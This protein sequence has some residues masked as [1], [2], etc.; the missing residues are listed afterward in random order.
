MDLR[1]STE[2]AL[3][4]GLLMS[5]KRIVEVVSVVS[6]S[7]FSDDMARESFLRIVG[8]WKDGRHVDAVTVM[9]G[10]PALVVFLS[11]AMSNASP[12]GVVDYARTI[13][14]L[15]R[16]DRINARLEK[17]S[18]EADNR[19]KLSGIMSLYQDEMHISAK[20]PSIGSVV[21][22]IEKRQSEDKK[23]G[24]F[25]FSTGFD[26]L[27]EIYVK[28]MPGHIWTMGAFTSVGKTAMMIQ[29][30]CNL[31]ISEKTPKMVIISTEMTEGQL[32]SRMLSNF[33]G[34]HSQRI[35]TAN[36]RQGEEEVVQEYKNMLKSK[37]IFI[38]DDIYELSDIETVF[39]KAK[40]KTGV[41]VG[42]IDYVQNCQVPDAKSQYQEQ[43]T[44]AK[45]IQKLAKDVDATII[46][47]SQVSN[48][49]GRGNTSQLE[50]KGAGEWAAV[51]DVGIML[52]R[53]AKDKYQLKYSVKKNRHGALCEH[54]FEYKSDFTRLE[55]TTAI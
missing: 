20:D 29:K 13:A 17:I 41:D 47:L 52:Q 14:D 40:L 36:Y 42:F 1:A 35:L 33:T 10:N 5:Q 28:Y 50:L 53:N 30:V 24:R 6:A 3:I 7:D 34:V 27:D 31:V 32:I 55:P 46:C 2:K 18:K 4:G 23:A 15:A 9:D 49:V 12:A 48:D 43:S 22:R 45:R 16:A 44:L 26:F 54:M 39:H 51:S 25:G 11:E 38:C 8:K 21:G 19:E 37:P